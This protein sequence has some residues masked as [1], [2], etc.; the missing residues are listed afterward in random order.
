MK[1]SSKCA[2]SESIRQEKIHDSPKGESEVNHC[3]FHWGLLMCKGC[4]MKWMKE[5]F[6]CF[7]SSNNRIKLSL[8]SL[9]G[10]PNIYSATID[11]YPTLLYFI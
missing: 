11:C 1:G 7:S 2:L 9:F 6:P 5:A 3:S 10:S 4:G 8:S